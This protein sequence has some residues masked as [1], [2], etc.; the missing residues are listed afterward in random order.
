VRI[1]IKATAVTFV[2]FVFFACLAQENGKLQIHFID[3]GQGDA[4]IL[5]SPLGE[6]VL[7]DDGVL[8]KCDKPIAYLKKIGIKAIDYHVAS[9]YHSDHIG[10]CPQVLSEFPLQKDAYDHGGT[11]NSGVFQSYLEAIGSHRKTVSPGQ[12]TITLDPGSATPVTIKIVAA[13]G[14]GVQS[15]DE[16][17]LSV[18]AV[19]HFGAF[20]AEL[21]GDLSGFDTTSYKDI[22]TSVAD[23]VGQIDVYKVHHHGSSHSTNPHWLDVTKPRIGVISCG[24]GNTY[25]HPTQECLEALHRANVRTYWT[26]LGNGVDPE[27]G[28]DIVGGN[29]VVQVP[30]DSQTFSVTYNGAQTDT[31]PTWSANSVAASDAVVGVSPVQRYAWTKSRQSRIYHLVQCSDVDG[32]SAAN[33]VHGSTPPDGRS[34]HSKCPR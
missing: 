32:I 7:F 8:K 33:L 15:K 23:Q 14:N 34:L 6:T 16:N 20:K 1:W 22:E 2:C 19:V 9:H 18:D 5:I 17:D 24:T 11:Y 25:N 31:Y 26:E 29:I 10:C 4:A 3:C 27:P 30:A 12:T 13:N 21:G 28:M